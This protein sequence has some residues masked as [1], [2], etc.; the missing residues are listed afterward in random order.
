MS[1]IPNL[2]YRKYH[3]IFL[4]N[5][6]IEQSL[7]RLQ[8]KTFDHFILIGTSVGPL[9]FE[10]YEACRRILSRKLLHIKLENI[11]NGCNLIHKYSTSLRTYEEIKICCFSLHQQKKRNI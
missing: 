4:K 1:L 9:R 3:L 5:Y 2:L 6:K 7:Q 11:I 10:E 8:K